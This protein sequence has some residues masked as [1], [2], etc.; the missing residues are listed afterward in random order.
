MPSSHRADVIILTAIALE[1]EAVRQV[2]ASAWPG[3][4]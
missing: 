1:Y 3:S 4:R 2:D